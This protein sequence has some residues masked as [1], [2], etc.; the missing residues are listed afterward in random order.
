MEG[1][2]Y[3]IRFYNSEIEFWKI[4][5]TSKSIEKRFATIK[6]FYRKYA[7]KYE[8]IY[9]KKMS[10]KDAF[11]NEQKILKEHKDSRINI[12]YNNFRTTEAFNKD[13]R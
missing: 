3:Y 4:G 9:S 13:I 6:N 12:D 1:L 2:L 7:L 10:I 11:I 5:I 8:V